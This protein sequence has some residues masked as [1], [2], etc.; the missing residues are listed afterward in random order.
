MYNKRFKKSIDQGSKAETRFAT[1]ATKKGYETAKSSKQVDMQAHWDFRITKA[2]Y[3]K[4]VEVK[5]LKHVNDVL[6]DDLIYVELQN[7]GGGRGWLYAEADIMAFEMVG[8]FL[9]VQ[10][11]ELKTLVESLIDVTADS[12]DSACIKKP[13]I[14]YDRHKWGNKDRMVLIPKKD[15]LSLKHYE[16]SF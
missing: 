14:I 15:I 11:E 4:R 2:N 10:R 16:W 6:T 12:V 9:L 3:S 13:Y 5:A 1:I 8:Y 7:C